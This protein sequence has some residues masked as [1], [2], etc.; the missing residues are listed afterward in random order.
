VKRWTARLTHKGDFMGISPTGSKVERTGINTYRF[1][2]GKIVEAWS[3]SDALGMM[4]QLGVIPPL[5]VAYLVRAMRLHRAYRFRARHN[6]ASKL[7]TGPFCFPAMP[8]CAWRRTRFAVQVL[9]KRPLNRASVCGI[10]GT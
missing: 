3:N 9:R 5:S 2:D 1:A 6:G 7:S 8:T 4:Q 10:I